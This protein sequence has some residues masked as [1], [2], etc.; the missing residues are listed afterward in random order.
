MYS[1]KNTFINDEIIARLVSQ[2]GILLSGDY[3]LEIDSRKITASSIFCAYPGFIHDGRNYIAKALAAG[4]KA[5]LWEPGIATP[6][7]I[8][9]Y[10][11]ANL[12]QMV[13]ILAAHQNDFPSRQL[14]AIAV[15]GTNGKTSISHWLN[16]AYVY[17]GLKAA[18][19]G[20]TGAGIYPQ[21]D[22]YASTTPDPITL[23]HLLG[24][25]VANHAQVLAMEVS[26]HALSQGRVNGVNFTTAIFSNLTQ[27]HLDYHKT[28]E[29]YAAA[30]ELLF[31]WQSLQHAVINVDDKFGQQLLS[32]LAVNNPALELISYGINSGDLRAG[33]IKL[34]TAG[35]EFKLSYHGQQQSIITP[36]IGRF[37]IYNLLAVL[38]TLLVNGV[39]WDQLSAIAAILQPVTG[40][41]ETLIVQNYPLIVIDYAHT[42]DALEKALLTLREF[43]AAS[44]KLIVVFGCGGNRDHGKRPL[45]G[46]I[47]ASYADEIIVT[48][49]NPRNE[50]PE[51]IID[52]IVAGIGAK[53]YQR[54]SN[55]YQALEK[56]LALA[57]AN[58]IIL[59]AGKGHETYQEIA[60]VKQ[61]FSDKE[62]L[63][64]IIN[65]C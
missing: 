35:S 44:G 15:T 46:E 6:Q 33:E 52:E 30:K 19:V 56:A 27:D 31:Y 51:L 23:Q 47:A 18:I 25:F 59:V 13:G 14:L 57:H 17:L 42:P 50:D 64:E 4:A 9:N 7:E 12:M 5:V 40:R 58:D 21:I 20:T 54:E 62:S 37:N 1:L 26:S 61:H 8:I 48:S 63:M 29:N 11:V 32:S 3:R 60:G 55:R 45:M 24:D 2:L 39:K 10:P 28:M 53:T 38:A 41:M 34:T 16:Q 43:K 22:D 49:D 36:V 65:E